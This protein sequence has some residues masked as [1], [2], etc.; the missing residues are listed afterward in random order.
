MS[1]DLRKKYQMILSHEEQFAYAL[2]R[3]VVEKPEASA[4][5]IVVPILFV[6]HFM[7]IKEYKI[8]VRTFAESILSTKQKALNKA[9]IETESGKKVR[10]EIE[11]YFPEVSLITTEEIILAQKEIQVI[12]VLED[13]YRAML[14]KHGNTFEEWVRKVYPGPEK[15]RK[16]LDRLAEREKKVIQYLMDNFHRSEESRKVARKIEQH[17][18]E[19]R[20]QELRI[21]F[22]QK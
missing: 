5:M 20:K 22:Q 13:H 18:D 21:F 1:S 4:W 2:A 3:N 15:Y 17:C 19:L 9:Y 11:D 14:V 16:F 8:G 10:Y 7:M 12:N 6:H